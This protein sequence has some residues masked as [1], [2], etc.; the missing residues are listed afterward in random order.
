MKCQRFVTSFSEFTVERTGK[1]CRRFIIEV[2]QTG[3]NT[4]GSCSGEFPG[5]T[6]NPLPFSQ[7]AVTCLTGTQHDQLRRLT[8]PVN[9]RNINLAIRKLEGR[10][11]VLSKQK[12][13]RASCRERVCRYV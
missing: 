5:K 11:L 1:F 4:S 10:N 13:G 9:I 12:I 7:W 3:N 2:P 6:N 8:I